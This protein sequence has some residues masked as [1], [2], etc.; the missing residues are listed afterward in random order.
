M[1]GLDELVAFIDRS[2]CPSLLLS[3]ETALML[4]GDFV[5]A[6]MRLCDMPRSAALR[7]RL[8]GMIEPNRAELYRGCAVAP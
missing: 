6:V 5:D 3:Y 1:R 4:P 7:A 2:R 8:I